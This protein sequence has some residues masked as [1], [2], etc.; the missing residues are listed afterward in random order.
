[1]GRAFNIEEEGMRKI[2]IPSSAGDLVDR[3]TILEVKKRYITDDKKLA[4]IE[5]HLI[6]LRK[7]CASLPQSRI[8]R[9]LQKKLFETNRRQWQLENSVRTYLRRKKTGAAFVTLVRSIHLSNDRRTALKRR[10]DEYVG[11]HIVE[12]KHYA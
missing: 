9:D 12:E 3:I 2:L 5:L 11:S 8:L 4:H 7:V 6:E 10:I 1:L